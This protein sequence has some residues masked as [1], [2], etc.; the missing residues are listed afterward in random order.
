MYI[1]AFIP[2]IDTCTYT[3]LLCQKFF[4][5]A[6][7]YHELNVE[8]SL[9]MYGKLGGKLKRQQA[10]GFKQIPS[11]QPA[12]WK[13]KPHLLPDDSTAKQQATSCI[14]GIE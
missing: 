8:C 1:Y 13:A 3:S 14:V 12:H 2:P 6:F 9:K 10:V 4:H 7:M 11:L 5:I